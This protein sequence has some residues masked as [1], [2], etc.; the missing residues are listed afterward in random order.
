MTCCLEVDSNPLQL[1]DSMEKKN[2]NT[3]KNPASWR[4][5]YNNTVKENK[6]PISTCTRKH[7]NCWRDTS[8]CWYASTTENRDNIIIILE[9]M[10]SPCIVFSIRKQ[11]SRYFPSTF[12]DL[13]SLHNQQ[14]ALKYWT[15]NLIHQQVF[16]TNSCQ[17]TWS[18]HEKSM[19][20][21]CL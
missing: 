11:F 3:I 17:V 5:T 10:S 19:K 4:K 13:A 9:K 1:F 16:A 6:L 2:Q 15:T 18:M 14:W 7:H 12:W 21:Q 20:S 8:T